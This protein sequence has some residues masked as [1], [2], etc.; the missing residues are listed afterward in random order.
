MRF[1]NWVQQQYATSV[2][3]LTYTLTIAN[4]SSTAVEDW[5]AVDWI[6]LHVLTE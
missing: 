3:P 4:I 5:L 1:T 2:A 6:A